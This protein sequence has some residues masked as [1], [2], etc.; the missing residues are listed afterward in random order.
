MSSIRKGSVEYMRILT[1]KLLREGIITSCVLCI[2]FDSK[3]EFCTLAG[4]RPPAK[5]I[6]TGCPQWL[7]DLPF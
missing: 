7:D 1:E 2:N 5:V 4:E 3:T 6:V